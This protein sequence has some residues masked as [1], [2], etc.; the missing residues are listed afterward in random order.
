MIAP[1]LSVVFGPPSSR[2]P[3]PGA[4]ELSTVE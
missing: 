1:E 4:N 3:I 2:L